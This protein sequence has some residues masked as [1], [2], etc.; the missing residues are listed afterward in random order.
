MSRRRFKQ[1]QQQ[2]VPPTRS[3]LRQLFTASF[4]FSAPSEWETFYKESSEVLEWHSS[5]PLERIAS[6]IPSET[7]SSPPFVILMV[8]CGNS[9]LP[10]TLLARN[11]NLKIVLL[12]TSQTCLDQL[13]FIYGTTVEYVC[14]NAIQLDRLFGS[15]NMATAVSRKFDMIIDKGL[16]DALFCSEGWNGPVEELYKSAANVLKPNGKYLLVSYRLPSST[17]E[18]LS[19]VG[20]HAN[21]LWEFDIPNDSN[22]RVGVSLAMKLEDD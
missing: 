1:P 7:D 19:E 5:V 11:A 17:K 4:D 14:G 2:H 12:D 15:P 6:F 13:Q 3:L 16:S 21:L 10:A 8:G 22:E 20:Q 18:F 9:R